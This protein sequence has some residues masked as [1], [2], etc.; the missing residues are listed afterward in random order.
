MTKTK[1]T[2]GEKY[3]Q[4]ADEARR[5]INASLTRQV[6]DVLGLPSDLQSV[7]V[8]HLWGDRFRLNVLVGT[9]VTSATVAHSYFLAVGGD[10]LI[11]EATPALT[12]HYGAAGRT[13]PERN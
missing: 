13:A 8:R 12:R 6:M 10:G 1:D 4:Y 7:Q 9:D 11:V 5:E 3:Q 2:S